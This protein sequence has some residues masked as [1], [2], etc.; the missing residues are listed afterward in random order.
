MTSRRFGTSVSESAP[1]EVTTSFSST[2]TPGSGVG[3]EPVAMMIAF[4]S[5]VRDG[6]VGA[7]DVDFVAAGEDAGAVDVFDLVLLEQELDA[8]GQA[9]DGLVLVRHHRGQDRRSTPLVLMPS[10]G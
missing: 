7:A 3:S 2:V 4:A 9:V 6:A 5:T 8:F 10:A 1:V